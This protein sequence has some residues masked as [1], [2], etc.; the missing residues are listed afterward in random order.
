[1]AEE[2]NFIFE[3]ELFDIETITSL[4]ES[5]KDPLLDIALANYYFPNQVVDKLQ[6]LIVDT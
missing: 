1:M 4:I 3:T 6:Q 2:I 5:A